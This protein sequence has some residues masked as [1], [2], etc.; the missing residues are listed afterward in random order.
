MTRNE[1]LR[2]MFAP[3][4]AEAAKTWRKGDVAREIARREGVSLTTAYSRIK[5]QIAH[6]GEGD[7][8]L[9]LRDLG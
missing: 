8:L 2:A 6:S 9:D 3:T 5:W 1:I 4:D 7:L